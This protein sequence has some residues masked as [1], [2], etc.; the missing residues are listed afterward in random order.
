MPKQQ[1]SSGKSP[2][3][4]DPLEIRPD[5]QESFGNLPWSPGFLGNLPDD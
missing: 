5:G 1:E 3:Y 2:Y 4:K